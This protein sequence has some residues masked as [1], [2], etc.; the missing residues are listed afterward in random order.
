[1]TIAN[2]SAHLLLEVPSIGYGPIIDGDMV[3]DLPDTLLKHGSYH[4]SVERIIT[5]NMVDDGNLG[6][7]CGYFPAHCSTETDGN[8]I[9]K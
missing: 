8:S 6:I 2:A 1:M 9:I 3:T 5:S 7:V 4:K